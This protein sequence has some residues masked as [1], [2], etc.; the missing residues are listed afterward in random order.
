MPVYPFDCLNC[1]HHED[2]IKS[3]SEYQ[4]HEECPKCTATMQR[5]F[6]PTRPESTPYQHPIEMFGVAPENPAELADLRR[7]MP[8]VELTDQLV[9]V[10][11]TYQQ[12]KQILAATGF[13]DRS[14]RGG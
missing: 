7:K 1:G 11:R 3:I 6:A 2:I 5:D 9:P 12:K 14:G 13:E 8:D 10:A 4:E